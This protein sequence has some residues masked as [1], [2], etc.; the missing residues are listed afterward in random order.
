MIENF[1]V[2][3]ILGLDDFLE[4]QNKHQIISKYSNRLVEKFFLKI[5]IQGQSHPGTN[6]RHNCIRERKLS[7]LLMKMG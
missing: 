7:V 4:Y 5:F 2:Q 6:T 3:N 1:F